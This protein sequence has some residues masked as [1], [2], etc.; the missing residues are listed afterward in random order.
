MCSKEKNKCAARPICPMK[1]GGVN[2]LLN[3]QTPELGQWQY[4]RTT[5]LK[6]IRP[7]FDKMRSK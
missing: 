2:G 5:K 3:K 1:I 4:Y 7:A 6:T